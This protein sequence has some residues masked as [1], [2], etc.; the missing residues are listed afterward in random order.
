MVHLSFKKE[1]T[2]LDGEDR[3]DLGRV[4]DRRAGM[5]RAHSVKVSKN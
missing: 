4:R 1:D 3:W 2:K 5:T